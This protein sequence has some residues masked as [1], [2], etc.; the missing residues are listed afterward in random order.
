MSEATTINGIP[1]TQPVEEA[2]AT[3]ATALAT[4]ALHRGVMNE[5]REKVNAGYTWATDSN[6][7][8][9]VDPLNEQPVIDE[10][11]NL[12][13]VA[14]DPGVTYAPSA[15]GILMF[16]Y[17]DFSLQLYLLGGIGAAA[18]DRTVTLTVQASDDVE[19]PAATRIWVDITAAGYNLRTNALGAASFTAT[20]GVTATSEIVDWDELDCKRVRIRY[21]WDADPSVTNGII[22]VRARRKAL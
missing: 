18:T 6:R 7:I 5:Y 8:E 4:G 14:A 13:A 20:G 9:E 10:L 16:G 12:Q 2:R 1:V 21:D 22:V 11:V 19:V 17:K 15:D 3:Q